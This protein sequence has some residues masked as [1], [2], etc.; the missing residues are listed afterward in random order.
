MENTNGNNDN[1]YNSNSLFINRLMTWYHPNYYKKL[2]ANRQQATSLE[3]S[4]NG[5]VGPEPTSAKRKNKIVDSRS[6]VGYSGTRVGAGDT[7]SIGTGDAPLKGPLNASRRD[8][9]SDCIVKMSGG[10]VTRS[11]QGYGPS[12]NPRDTSTQAVKRE[13]GP[14]SDQAS[15]G[16]R[17]N[18]R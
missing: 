18:K 17:I 11:S 8:P 4:G 9:E 3:S 5:R 13:G 16:S 7:P 12:K 14:A 6:Q 10:D 15:S 2:R 1:Q